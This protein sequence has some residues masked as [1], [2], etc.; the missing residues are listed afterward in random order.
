LFVTC[1][2]ASDGLT[3]AVDD[4]GWHMRKQMLHDH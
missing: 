1:K 2:R 4:I 3:V